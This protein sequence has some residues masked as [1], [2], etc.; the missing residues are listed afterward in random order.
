MAKI[1]IIDRSKISR[2]LKFSGSEEKTFGIFLY[3]RFNKFLFSLVFINY[4][5]IYINHEIMNQYQAFI[6][7][8]PS[9]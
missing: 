3:L 9:L 6:E 5:N 7:S 2:Y 1:F 4:L 8:E